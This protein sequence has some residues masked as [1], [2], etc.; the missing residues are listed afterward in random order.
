MISTTLEGKVALVTGASRGIGKAIAKSLAGAGASVIGTS[1]TEEGA[2]N[3][4]HYFSRWGLPGDGIVMDVAD[5]DSIQAGFKQVATVYGQPLIVVNNAGITKDGLLMRM[6][7]EDWSK[8]IDT[9][10]TSVYRMSKAAIKAM[11]KARW[12]RIINISSVVASAGNPG[13]MNY[14]AAKAGIE[15]MSRSLAREM[16]T[17]GIT[18]NCIA[19]GFIDTDMTRELPYDQR[20]QMLA[21]IP[22]Q[23]LGE[24]EE[25]AEA[26]AFLASPAAGY[27]TGQTL[28]INGGMYM[29]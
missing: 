26:V 28:H 23:R 3:I 10:L 4:S 15:G 18:V 21:G 27:I 7:E 5:P 22:V 12:G 11:S 17:R 1:T 16:A 25:V 9:N 29:G 13:Q 8:V 2:A 24:P 20:E 19:P 14:C 6:K